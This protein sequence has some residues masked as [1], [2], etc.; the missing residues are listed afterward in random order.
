M[1]R[2]L[3]TPPILAVPV[4]GKPFLL[5]VRAMEHSLGVLQAQHNY[6]GYEQVI[7]YVSKTLIG[8]ESRYNPVEEECLALVFAV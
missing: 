5:Y 8:A 2:Y 1:K 6:E 4:S 7:Y 3:T